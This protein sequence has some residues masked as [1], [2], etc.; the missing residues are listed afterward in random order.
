MIISSGIKCHTD[1]AVG[2]ETE[3][4][5]RVDEQI[6]FVGCGQQGAASGLAVSRWEEGHGK[7][8]KT[9]GQGC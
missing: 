2:A 3:G 7:K 8:I 9:V 1:N 6:D 4:P 5:Y